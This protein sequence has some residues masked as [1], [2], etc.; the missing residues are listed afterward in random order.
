M[1]FCL[2]GGTLR[3]FGESLNKDVPYKTL[4][5]STNDTAASVVRDILE[6]YGRDREE[7]V[8]YCL[9]ELIV[10]HNITDF[11]AAHELNGGDGI[12][13]YILDDD[14]CPLAIEKQHLR[15]RGS[16][17][18]HIKRRPADYQVCRIT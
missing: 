14:D 13:E 16:L 6:K 3:I 7:A 1:L 9:V 8:Q 18:F 5:L 15:S 12:R 4:L 2:I 10:P 17:S 11:N